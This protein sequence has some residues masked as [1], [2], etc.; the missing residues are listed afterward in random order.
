[1]KLTPLQL[2]VAKYYQ[3]GEYRGSTTQADYTDMGDTLFT[4]IM[5]EAEDAT[6]VTELVEMLDVARW[7]LDQL[8]TA[9][10]T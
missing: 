7:Q 3:E 9:L 6:T 5:Q 10:L 1:M 4:Y 2:L 8:I